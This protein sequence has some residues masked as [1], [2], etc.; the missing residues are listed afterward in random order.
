MEKKFE[1]NVLN[2]TVYLISM[3]MQISNVAVNYR[4]SCSHFLM[5]S[6][7]VVTIQGHPFMASLRENHLLCYSLL[8]AV[9]V[10][11]LLASGLMPD[12]AEFLEVVEFPSE[13]WVAMV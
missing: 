6:I 1:Q 8:G 3:T 11:F 7:D 2:S 12:L 4:V 5:W 13:V 10:V 9:S